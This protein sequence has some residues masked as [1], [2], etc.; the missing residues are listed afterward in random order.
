MAPTVL[1]DVRP[2]MRIAQEEIFGPIACLMRFSDEEEALAIANGTEYGLTA[3]LCTR[4]EGA[5]GDLPRA[6]RR[7]WCSSTTT[8]AG[9]SS[10]RPSGA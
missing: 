8:C 4:D 10:A 9:R 6:S 7:A 3:A 1:A 5:P 2:E